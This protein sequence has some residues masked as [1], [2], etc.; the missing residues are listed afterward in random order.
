MCLRAISLLNNNP[1]LAT[2]IKTAWLCHCSYIYQPTLP[3]TVLKL[4]YLMSAVTLSAPPLCSS[5][6]LCHV[7]MHFSPPLL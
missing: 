6:I 7:L 3:L 2:L 1:T 4:S 5:C